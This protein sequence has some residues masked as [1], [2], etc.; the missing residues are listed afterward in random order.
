MFMMRGALR[1]LSALAPPL[2]DRLAI[3]LFCRPRRRL[4]EPDVPG[5]ACHRWRVRTRVGWLNAWDYG[6]GP[7]VLLVHGWSGGAAQWS[8]FIAPLVRGGYNAVALDLPAHGFSDG[9][10][11]SLRDFVDAVLDT[12]DRVKPIHAVLGHSLGA[13]AATLA[14]ARGLHAGRAVLIAPTAG[15]VAGYLHSFARQLGLPRAQ[16]RRLVVRMQQRF[17]DLG[18]FDAPRAAEKLSTRALV[19]HDVDDPEIAFA[20]GE[21]LA[22]AWPGA[23]LRPLQGLGHN[24]PLKDPDIVREAVDFIAAR[25]PTERAQSAERLSA[26]R[27][28]TLAG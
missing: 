16:Q 27:R 2:G 25:T 6:A 22:R 11:S 13:T 8:R 18:Q 4:Q 10:R 23:R 7:T 17:G 12:A 5:V 15:D 19:F 3:D 20:E 24:R 9:A 28:P 1:A 21:S 26:T 14:L